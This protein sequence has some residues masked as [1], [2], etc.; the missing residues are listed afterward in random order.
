[1]NAPHIA[2]EVSM[3]GEYESR[4]DIPVLVLASLIATALAFCALR[5]FG[6]ISDPRFWWRIT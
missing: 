2:P 3:Y 1:M 4:Y 5:A 6:V